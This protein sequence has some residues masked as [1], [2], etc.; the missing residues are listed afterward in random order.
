MSTS[1]S[2]CPELPEFTMLCHLLC[3]TSSL[4]NGNGDISMPEYQDPTESTDMYINRYVKPSRTP[5][6]DMDLLE[7]DSV[8][9]LLIRDTDDIISACYQSSER[10]TLTTSLAA[11]ADDQ[12]P[13]EPK[14]G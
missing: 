7:L 14:N 2:G 9:A 6:E 11:A 4:R 1:D 12:G 13:E 5:H 8:T 10:I 3:L